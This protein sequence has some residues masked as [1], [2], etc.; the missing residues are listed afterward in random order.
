M[1]YVA[2]A[3]VSTGVCAKYLLFYRGSVSIFCIPRSL[4]VTP[5]NIN[6]FTNCMYKL[7]SHFMGD[8]SLSVLTVFE[9]YF[10]VI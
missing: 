7:Y 1:S 4:H 10:M 8:L 2:L 6:M 3:G 5:P 9:Y